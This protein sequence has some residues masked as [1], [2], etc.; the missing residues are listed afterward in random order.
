MNLAYR[1]SQFF[2]TLITRTAAQD[3]D[4][5]KMHLSPALFRLFQRMSPADQAH[6]IRVLRHLL[7]E[8]ESHPALLAAALLHDVGKLHVKPSI[9]ERVLAVVI[10]WFVP[11]ATVR[12]GKGEP[13]G[14]RKPFV[15]AAQHPH[16]GAEMISSAG[17]EAALVT[18]VRRHQEPLGENLE[19][20]FERKLLQLQEADRVS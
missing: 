2:R 20:E 18:L 19:D 1:A 17:G 15:I 14:W 16:W 12:W 3:N 10:A 13:R 4:L 11:D 7:S 5:V 9:W 6:G 8:G